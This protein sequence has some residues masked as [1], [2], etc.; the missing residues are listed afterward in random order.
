MDI[1]HSFPYKTLLLYNTISPTYTI[2]SCAILVQTRS[3]L[4][5]LHSSFE[6]SQW[7]MILSVYLFIITRLQKINQVIDFKTR[8]L[9]N[10]D[11]RNRQQNAQFLSP[12]LPQSSSSSKSGSIGNKVSLQRFTRYIMYS[13]LK[14]VYKRNSYD[15]QMYNI[16]MHIIHR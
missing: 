15:I 6:I 1:E 14:C 5:R 3:T 11:Q 9:S 2:S 4:Y 16:L 13:L 12:V 7:K 10:L 8:L